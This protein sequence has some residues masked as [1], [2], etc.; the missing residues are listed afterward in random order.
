MF[1]NLKLKIKCVYRMTGMGYVTNILKS[2][3][4][5]NLKS[6]VKYM[7]DLSSVSHEQTFIAVKYSR[8]KNNYFHSKS[9]H[10][11]S[12]LRIE[13]RETCLDF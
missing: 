5:F 7:C 11:T 12:E 9:I 8:H 10:F 2:D 4:Y 3:K 1:L 6:R 13:K